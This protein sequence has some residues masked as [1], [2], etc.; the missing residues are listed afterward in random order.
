MKRVI[1]G[2]LIIDGTGTPAERGDLLLSGDRIEARLA[3]GEAVS[4]DAVVIDASGCFVC[5]GFIDV[6]S[7]ADNSPLLGFDDQSKIMQGVTTEVVGNCGFS[8]APAVYERRSEF[9]E[10]LRRLFPPTS[11]AW[12]SFA[13]FTAYVDES[14]T[15]TNYCPLVGHGALRFG[16]VGM[17]RH[18][19]DEARRAMRMSLEEALEAGAFGMSSGLV[20]PPGSF[21]DLDEICMLA[22]VLEGRVYATHQRAE[23]AHLMESLDEALSVVRRTGCRLQVSHL[24]AMGRPNWGATRSALQSID[25]A[26]ADGALVAQD[27]YPYTATSTTLMS[28]LPPEFLA[29]T[30]EEVI[31][32]LRGTGAVDRLGALLASGV[33]SWENR[34]AYAGWDGVLIA[35]AASG[36]HEGQTLAEIADE[37]GEAPV[38]TLVRLLVRERLEITASTFLMDEGDIATVLEHPQTMIG[39]DGLPVGASASH[40]PRLFGTF[41]RILARY[42][43]DGCPLS[44]HE[45]IRRMTSLPADWFGIPGRG[46]I[47]PGMVAD[48]VIVDPESVRDTATYENPE[49][50]PHG[51]ETVVLSGH[52]VVDEAGF[53]GGRHGSRL[54]PA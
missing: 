54:E 38:Q 11:V 3:P 49:Q 5:P 13:Q 9:E 30:T 7:H 22:E 37:H 24:K 53:R 45:A 20:Y 29:G 2:G 10:Y 15:V 43:G 40:N 44:M 48:L 42:V 1:R 32:R 8:L 50:I 26:S 19:G 36:E 47:A 35:H 52:V 28:L 21:A 34:V 41:P 33:D 14:G 51:I 6:H 4:S 46:R 39:S 17:A 27:V 12:S 25:R 31:E 16:A 18:T 23:G